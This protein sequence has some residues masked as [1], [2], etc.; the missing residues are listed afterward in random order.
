M[1]CLRK[2][3]CP[4]DGSEHFLRALEIAVQAAKKFDGQIA[5]IHEYSIGVAPMVVPEPAT[6]IPLMVPALPPVEA[7]KVAEAA[8]RAGFSILEDGERRVKG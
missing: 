2:S 7:S 8:L 1:V 6:Q 4:L 5:L 3:W